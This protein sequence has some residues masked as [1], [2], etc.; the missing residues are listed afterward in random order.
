MSNLN[1]NVV[2]DVRRGWRDGGAIEDNLPPSIEAGEPVILREGEIVERQSDGTVDH[3]SDTATE[4]SETP[5]KLHMVLQ[6]NDQWDAAFVGKVTVLRGLFT[7][8]TEKFVEPSTEVGTY[9]PGTLLTYS[10]DTGT[11]GFLRP[12]SGA[13]GSKEFVVGEVVDY[14]DEGG[15]HGI[16][17]AAL[18]LR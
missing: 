12:Q 2:F 14:S 18:N 1:R 3:P 7:I 9:E 10:T 17:V 15:D 13:T 11:E 16:L 5:P 4:R 8:R 6:G